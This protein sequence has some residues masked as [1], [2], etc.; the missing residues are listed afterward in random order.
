MHYFGI[1][2]MWKGAKVTVDHSNLLVP[3]HRHPFLYLTNNEKLICLVYSIFK[4]EYFVRT[5]SCHF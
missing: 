2:G 1:F 3:D 4:Q 5:A